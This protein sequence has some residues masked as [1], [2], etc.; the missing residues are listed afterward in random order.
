MQHSYPLPFMA[1]MG[2][3]ISA[4]QLGLF[5]TPLHLLSTLSPFLEHSFSPRQLVSSCSLWVGS[6]SLLGLCP[7]LWSDS[8]KIISMD[9]P[10]HH[11][12]LEP[13]GMPF[14]AIPAMPATTQGLASG[15]TQLITGIATV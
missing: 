10:P 1:C 12:S 8:Y 5:A 15:G 2:F 7:C 13:D 6:C 11:G 4:T 9:D 14:T 3:G